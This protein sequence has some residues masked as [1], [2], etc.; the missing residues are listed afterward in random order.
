MQERSTVE[1]GSPD[2]TGRGTKRRRGVREGETWKRKAKPDADRVHRVKP[3]KAPLRYDFI[4]GYHGPM[5]VLGAVTTVKAQRKFITLT[6]WP[7]S[8][9]GAARAGILTGEA[10]L[11]ARAISAMSTRYGV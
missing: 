6:V 10:A 5:C 9:L 1:P 8:L 7:E 4:D 11:I 2:E 3:A